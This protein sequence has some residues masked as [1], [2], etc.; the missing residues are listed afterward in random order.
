MLLWM[1]MR[2]STMIPASSVLLLS[3]LLMVKWLMSRLSV[4]DLEKRR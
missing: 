2:T 3:L 1:A 4:E